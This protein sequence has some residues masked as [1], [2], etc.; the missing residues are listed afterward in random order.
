M[1]GID[2]QGLEGLDASKTLT[3]DARPFAPPG[4]QPEDGETVPG[5]PRF[6]WQDTEDAQSY[7]FQ[8]ARD[9]GFASPAIDRRGLAASELTP[10]EALASGR[11]YWRVASTDA[12]GDDG[13]W[14]APHTVEV[15]EGGSLWRFAPL[16][17]VPIV[18]LVLLL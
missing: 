14:S 7:R 3:L 13:P 5:R 8:L 11:W 12:A 2:A 16:A 10:D 6:D 18:L 15:E 9:D 1:R 4:L 17:L